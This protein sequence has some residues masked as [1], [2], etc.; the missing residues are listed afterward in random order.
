MDIFFSYF[1]K[2]FAFNWRI[3][4]LQYLAG[5]CHLSTWISHRYIHGPS[6]PFHPI[7]LVYHRAPDL[8]SLWS[9]S[10]SVVSNSLQP[11]GLQPARLL[12][13]WDSLG[14]DIGVGS[15]SLLRGSSWPRYRTQ[16]SHIAG[17]YFPVWPTRELS[18]SYSEFPLANFTYDNVYVLMLLS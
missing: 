7:P 5:F 3:I 18:A 11:C 8:S 6:L 9:E 16:V 12:C 17:G 2:N 14:K 13:P 10:C 15:L 1:F 4:A